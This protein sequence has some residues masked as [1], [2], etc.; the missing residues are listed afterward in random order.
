[1]LENLLGVEHPG[2]L[3]SMANLASTLW[4]QGR[5]SQA[6]ELEIRVMEKRK[7]VVRQEHPDTLMSMVDL[8]YT[9][10]SQGRVAEALKLLQEAENVLGK[11][12]GHEHPNTINTTQTLHDWQTVE[13]M[14]KDAGDGEC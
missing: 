5:W 11:V 10:K 13:T 2:T 4:D 7:R 8:A 6:E 9:W 3:T 12:L 14:S 1:M